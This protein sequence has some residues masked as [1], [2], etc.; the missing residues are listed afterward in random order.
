M[1]DAAPAGALSEIARLG[2][3]VVESSPEDA[4]GRKVSAG[5]LHNATLALFERHGFERMRPLAKRHWLVRTVVPP[6]G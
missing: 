1:A 4:T 2:G 6:A 3:G 5:F